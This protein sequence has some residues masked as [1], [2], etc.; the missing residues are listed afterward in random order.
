MHPEAA[1]ICGTLSCPAAAGERRA[2]SRGRT[3]AWGPCQTLCT[4]MSEPPATAL[5]F[6][7]CLV[8]LLSSRQAAFIW[9]M[10]MQL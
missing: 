8:P 9:G 2:R 7:M 4:W 1:W 3:L 6:N 5:C 10:Q